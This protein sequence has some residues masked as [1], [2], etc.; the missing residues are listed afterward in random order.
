MSEDADEIL[1]NALR[2]TGVAC[3]VQSIKEIE[4]EVLVAA[5]GACL[6]L[7]TGTEFPTEM[8]GEMSGRFAVCTQLA[9]AIKA[10]GYNSEIGF[11][12][13]LYPD[14]KDVKRLLQ[15]LVNNLPED[16]AGGNMQGGAN[17]VLFAS[18][19]EELGAWKK[20]AWFPAFSDAGDACALATCPVLATSSDDATY[21]GAALPYVLDQAPA[22]V[23]MA[24]SLFEHNMLE[25]AR[26]RQSGGMDDLD[27]AASGDGGRSV[28]AN[29]LLKNGFRALSAA[30]ETQGFDSLVASLGGADCESS[31][32]T[33]QTAFVQ[34][35]EDFS[36]GGD[37][38]PAAPQA[39]ET[40][41]EAQ[42]R[43]KQE[44]Q[45]QME[46]E[47]RELE[48]RLAALLRST[49]GEE[50]EMD[51]LL[52]QIRQLDE[53]LKAAT[54]ASK[55][56]E[57]EYL[58]KKRTLELLD[59]PEE[60]TKKLQAIC[61]K[62][63]GKL[64]ELAHEWEGHRKPLIEE[65]RKKKDVIAR[66]KDEAKLKLGKVKEMREETKGMLAELRTKEETAKTL[67]AELEKLPRDVKRSA[68]VN[69]ILDIIRNVNKQRQEI[70][71]ILQDIRD[72]RKD[73]NTG[74]SKL[75]RSFAA[76]DETVFK[77]AKSKPDYKEVYKIL[78][79]MHEAFQKLD[80]TVTENGK[81][82]NEIDMI[83]AKISDMAARN[84]AL[85]MKRCDGAPHTHTTNTC[86]DNDKTTMTHPNLDPFCNN[87]GLT[88]PLFN[89]FWLL[90]PCVSWSLHSQYREGPQ[91]DQGREC[92]PRG[93]VQGKKGRTQEQRLRW[94]AEVVNTQNAFQSSCCKD[95]TAFFAT[96]LHTRHLNDAVLRCAAGTSCGSRTS[97]GYFEVRQ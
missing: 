37:E 15:W 75:E 41:A 61:D 8:P 29:G 67:A 24:S 25:L 76:T 69:R 88:R 93:R 44:L 74:A 43:K 6:K 35:E 1:L 9:E 72:A 17:V 66:R 96:R 51:M 7:M 48:E 45:D 68:Y 34:E 57:E 94:F 80:D 20:Q 50:R 58:I 28:A 10:Q 82:L 14:E 22:G 97:A 81:A 19:L 70:D 91:G 53:N 59:N 46:R 12:Q 40:P 65:Y 89:M 49:E 33:R 84:D 83:Q 30:T 55:A 62:T 64:L 52:A 77:D 39:G 90:C 47:I 73:V 16:E 63:A 18:I 23:S 3:P 78:V 54:L 27:M 4:S 31:I 21:V 2:E 56:L 79:E 42:K 5:A 13:F 32:F 95:R 11:Q 92:G 36:M 86:I 38:A 87:D 71:K 85:D 26:G 60:N